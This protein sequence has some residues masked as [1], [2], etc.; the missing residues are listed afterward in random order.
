MMKKIPFLTDR[1]GLEGP[2][3]LAYTDKG[4]GGMGGGSMPLHV[5]YYFDT[6]DELRDWVLQNESKFGSQ[7]KLEMFQLRM[8]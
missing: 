6:E 1:E 8:P 7:P 2:F 5:A 3:V 4:P